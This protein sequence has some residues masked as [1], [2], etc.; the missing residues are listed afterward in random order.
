MHGLSR[1]G[2]FA[3]LTFGVTVRIAF[4]LKQFVEDTNL[5]NSMLDTMSKKLLDLAA[6]VKQ[7]YDQA[8]A[9]NGMFREQAATYKAD[10][11]KHMAECHVQKPT[12][13]S[14]TFDGMINERA[15]EKVAH[16]FEELGIKPDEVSELVDLVEGEVTHVNSEPVRDIVD[17]ELPGVDEAFAPLEAFLNEHEPN[18]DIFPEVRP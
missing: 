6:F 9:A 16:L 8:S 11:E 18:E 2:L 7:R 4:Y 3:V 14:P 10:L 15:T 1:D 5:N 17:V 13:E 12:E